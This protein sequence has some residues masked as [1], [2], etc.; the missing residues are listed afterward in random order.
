MRWFFVLVL[1]INVAYMAWEQNKPRIDVTEA[2]PIPGDVPTIVLLSELGKAAKISEVDAEQP[3]ARGESTTVASRETKTVQQPGPEA[4]QADVTVKGDQC[5][6]LGPFRELAA[7]RD[8]TRAIKN[9]V[10]T[11]SFRSRD[12]KEQ[13][14][15]WVYLK[16]VATQTEAMALSRRL[17]HMNVK[18]Q[19]VI[20]SGDKV[21][22]VSL[23]HFREK[24]RAYSHAGSLKKQ[25]FNPLV[26]PVFKDYTLYW[27][28]YRVLPD[29]DIP[30]EVFKKHLTDK[31]NHL[32]R[33]CS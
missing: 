21:N 33:Q 19:Y 12:E 24:N 25:G 23:G 6:T 11:A 30:G 26:E 5:Y 9:Y 3:Q 27:L 32:Q 4:K 10:K 14:M 20:K 31:V 7:L 13:T 2:P 29:K 22:G 8:F 15:F 17:T 1:L 16:P 18:D 28:D